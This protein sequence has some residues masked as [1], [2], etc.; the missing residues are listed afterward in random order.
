MVFFFVKNPE[1]CIIEFVDENIKGF[2][3]TKHELANTVE[4]HS[5]VRCL[6]GFNQFQCLIFNMGLIY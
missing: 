2:N 6:D 1:I 4:P 5:K 3:D